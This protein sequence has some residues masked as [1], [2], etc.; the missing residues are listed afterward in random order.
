MAIPLT[1]RAWSS[2]HAIGATR[3]ERA[4]AVFILFTYSAKMPMEWFHSADF[5]GRTKNIS[6]YYEL[7]IYLALLGLACATTGWS[8]SSLLAAL[9]LEPLLPLLMAWILASALWATDP[10]ETFRESAHLLIVISFG[11]WLAVRF[12]ITDIIG[13]AAVA[14]AGA[15]LVHI[16]FIVLLPVYGDSV[17]GW[18]GTL[19]NKNIFARMMALHI[20]VFVLAA[21]SH[22]RHRTVLWMFAMVALVLTFGSTSKT[23][24]VVVMS[25]PIMAGVF[26][27]FRSR[28][29]LYGAV[30]VSMIGG[31][32]LATWIGIANRPEIAAALG[33]NSRL[34]GRTELWKQLVPELGRRPLQG[35][36]VGGYWTSH[37]NGP[38]APML[39]RLGWVAGH[40][41]NAF[42]QV[43]LDLGLIGFGLILLLTIRLIV[44]GARVLR[45]YRGAV[46]LFP[47]LFGILTVLI[48]ITEFGILRP[49]AILLF[50]APACIGAARGRRDVL[51]FERSRVLEAERLTRLQKPVRDLV[52]ASGLTPRT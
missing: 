38:N 32:A 41:H 49:D 29:T 28:R 12:S 6:G 43:T 18:V 37:W 11:Y 25:L 40:A 10:T 3:I 36:G 44:R 23:G 35:F 50:L 33:R 9:R 48:S 14:M 42:F 16:A 8:A 26:T 2:L 19:E 31:S 17:R 5:P 22:R 51:T 13:L 15:V 39:K 1:P 34:S 4:I 24:L 47:L 21:R 7:A 27:A 30:S 20:L 46:G 52:G 45:W